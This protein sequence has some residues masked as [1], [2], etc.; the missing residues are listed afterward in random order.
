MKHV[1][2]SATVPAA[3]D[4]DLHLTESNAILQYAA[5][6]DGGSKLYPKDLKQRASVNRWLLWEASV[7][8]PSCYVYLIENVVK[9]E[10]M[11]APPD[12]ATI[13][14][15]APKFANYASILDRQ[16]G[17]TKYIA[18]NDLTIADIAIASCL[19]L[20]AYMKLGL[21][22]YPN[23]QRW[24][25]AIESE[26]FWKK[27][28]PAV[29]EKLVPSKFKKVRASFNYTKDLGGDKL[30]ELY[31]YE[32][33]AARD[34]HEPGDDARELEVHD[35]WS[36]AEEFALDTH[37]FCVKDFK[38]AY[39]SSWED[40]EAVQS[41]FYPEVVDFLQKQTGAKRVLVFDHTIR[42]RKNAEKKLTQ[43]TN[44]SQRAPVA[45]V[46]CEYVNPIIPIKSVS[47]SKSLAATR[48]SRAL[49]E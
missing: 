23:L 37:G 32:D 44:T 30:T 25:A 22:K 17:K 38:P 20:H 2:P 40:S 19:H 46:H 3:V 27:T 11:G 43:E 29:E 6:L 33:V 7:F 8:F 35:G 28:Q 49:F 47:H 4:G 9:P 12:A 24:I 31:F 18:G 5:D 16:L 26:D 42:T 21:E 14:K 48:L 10:V 1:N 36:R 34:I 15:E 39:S 13:E 45:L 41:K